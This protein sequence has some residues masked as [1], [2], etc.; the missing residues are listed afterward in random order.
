VPALR[1]PI[2]IGSGVKRGKLGLMQMTGAGEFAWGKEMAARVA[3]RR[4]MLPLGTVSLSPLTP[5]CGKPK[6]HDLVKLNDDIPP[7]IV[8]L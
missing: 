4:G 8:S 6:N 2:L 1:S 3:L 7:C 5:P